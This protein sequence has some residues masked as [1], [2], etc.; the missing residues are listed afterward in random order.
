MA[1]TGLGTHIRQVG[2][3]A[4]PVADPDRAVTFYVDTLGLEKRLDAPFGDGDRWIEVA[5]AGAA[6]TI[7]LAPPGT[8][9]TGV[10][11]GIR[12]YA[13]DCE[14]A[15]RELRDSGADVGEVLHWPGVPPMFELRD[16]DGNTLYIV[17]ARAR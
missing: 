13:D 9:K 6:T 5:P 4:V 3:V 11:T 15:H 12:L 7:A 14:T 1:T 8:L 2:T 17:E 16:P 10:D